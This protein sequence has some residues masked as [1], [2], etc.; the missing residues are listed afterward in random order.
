MIELIV[1]IVVIGITFMSVPLIMSETERSV[2]TSVHQEAVM[3]GLSQ[4]VN[5]M[6]YKWDENQTDESLN[7]GYAKVLDTFYTNPLQCREISGTRMRIGHFQEDYR[8]KCY[9]EERNATAPANLGSD[10]GDMDDIDD[11]NGK[12]ASLLSGAG[13]N[14]SDYKQN[15]N[16]KISVVY[17]EDDLS[18]GNDYTPINIIG[19]VSTTSVTTEPT[20]IKMIETTISSDTSDTKVVMRSF[21]ANVGEVRYFSKRVGP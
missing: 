15:Y 12:D 9:N 2:E 5:I 6:S 13:N 10:G 18:N 11:I 17:V 4:M 20:S 7:G 19:T 1:A 8:R 3:A 16:I 14:E 21:A